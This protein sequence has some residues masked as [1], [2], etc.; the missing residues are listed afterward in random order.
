[1]KYDIYPTSFCRSR[2]THR[3]AAAK[4]KKIESCPLLIIKTSSAGKPVFLSFDEKPIMWARSSTALST[5]R[6]R[7]Q[8]QAEQLEPEGGEEERGERS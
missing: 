2:S 4:L 5:V 7:R 1:M 3:P 6:A 8:R